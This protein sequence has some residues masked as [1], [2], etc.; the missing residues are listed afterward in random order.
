MVCDNTTN[1]PCY[2]FVVFTSPEMETS[3]PFDW[4]P[5]SDTIHRTSHLH[6]LAQM[7]YCHAMN[8]RYAGLSH[9]HEPSHFTHGELL[10]VI[11]HQNLDQDSHK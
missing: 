3:Q 4:L 10:L 11:E 1:P 2:H 6:K 7:L 8:L 5:D 9:S